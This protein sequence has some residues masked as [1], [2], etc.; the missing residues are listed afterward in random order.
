MEAATNLNCPASSPSSPKQM[1]PMSQSC[2]NRKIAVLV[3]CLLLSGLVASRAQ[4]TGKYGHM[5][6]PAA[7]P[8]DALLLKLEKIGRSL[9]EEGEFPACG[10]SSERKPAG[11]TYFGQLIDHDVTFDP[12]PFKEANRWTAEDIKNGRTPWLDLDQVYGGGPDLSGQLYKGPKGEERFDIADNCDLPIGKFYKLLGD[13]SLPL[14]EQDFRDLENAIILQMHVLF[15]RL[16]NLAIERN[17]SCGIREVDEVDK[18]PFKKAA[19]LVRWQYQYLVRNDYLTKIADINIL[20]HVQTHGPAFKWEPGKVFIPVE[21]STAGFRFGHSAVLEEYALNQSNSFPIGKLIDLKL[22]T[23]RLPPEKVIDW[24]HFFKVR[25]STSPAAAGMNFLDMRIVPALGNLKQYTARLFSNDPLLDPSKA[26]APAD[27]GELPVR[28]LQRSAWMRVATGQD[29]ISA[30]KWKD[31]ELTSKQLLGK[32]CCKDQSP[33]KAGEAL[34]DAGLLQKTPLFFYVLREAEV[35]G[36]GK[37]LGPVGSQIVADVIEGAFRFDPDWDWKVR[38]TW[39]PPE[40]KFPSGEPR[41]IEWMGDL[42]EL[43]GDCRRSD[44]ASTAKGSPP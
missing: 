2:F 21:F 20:S 36:C 24:R 34:R 38:N 1:N 32:K 7:A 12:T 5:F 28:T 37:H 39:R 27:P 41:R 15:M 18:T 16:H 43:L 31:K 40:W 10:C 25:G 17:M 30:L 6:T 14:K 35:L 9:L 3:L 19:R 22:A 8:D 23:E 11:Y 42:V 44:S 29:I 4:T 13:Q 26:S 33:D